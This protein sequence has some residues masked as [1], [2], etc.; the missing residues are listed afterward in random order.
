MRQWPLDLLAGSESHDDG[1]VLAS[2]IKHSCLKIDGGIFRCDCGQIARGGMTAFAASG[3]IEKN[4]PGFWIASEKLFDRIFVGD[5]RRMERFSRSRV[6][7]RG[8]VEDLFVGERH[9][10]HAFIGAAETNDFADFVTLHVM[11]YQR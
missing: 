4:L 5:V 2:G 9:R 10:R 8:N 7:K 3:S 11:R 6:Q 1:G